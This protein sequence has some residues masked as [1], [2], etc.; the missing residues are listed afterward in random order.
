MKTSKGYCLTKTLSRLK[1]ESELLH[2]NNDDQ[3]RFL[4]QNKILLLFWNGLMISY[5]TSHN[6]PK[7]KAL[8]ASCSATHTCCREQCGQNSSWN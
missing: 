6:F 4:K 2:F 7:V 8:H 5:V 1:N 3:T